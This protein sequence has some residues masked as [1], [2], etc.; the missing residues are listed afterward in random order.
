MKL[1][2][3]GRSIGQ[4]AEALVAGYRDVKEDALAGLDSPDRRIRALSKFRIE[5][6]NSGMNFLDQMA[7][8]LYLFG[9]D[10]SQIPKGYQTRAKT[11]I[12]PV[13]EKA[14]DRL[15]LHKDFLADPQSLAK[16]VTVNGAMGDFTWWAPWRWPGEAV[17]AGKSVAVTVGTLALTAW[18]LKKAL[19]KG[20]SK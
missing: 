10:L 13:V 11:K 19:E 2:D 18:I 12:A 14:L 8:N 9:R 17:D 6:A 1:F 4:R 5:Q 15:E 7:G 20:R 16:R 3:R